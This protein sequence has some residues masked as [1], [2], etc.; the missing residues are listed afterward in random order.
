V[1]AGVAPAGPVPISASC[2]AADANRI[3]CSAQSENR[4]NRTAEAA[5]SGDP[6][7]ALA[8]GSGIFLA[9]NGLAMGV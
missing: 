6:G 5:R 8:S 9:V 7:D 2:D 4:S 3:G 1:I